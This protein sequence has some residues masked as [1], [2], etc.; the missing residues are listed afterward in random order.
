MF[1]PRAGS[2][3]KAGLADVLRRYANAVTLRLQHPADDD[4]VLVVGCLR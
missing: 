4:L 2:G 3:L 1:L